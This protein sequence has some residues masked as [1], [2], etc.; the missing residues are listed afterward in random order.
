MTNQG[1]RNEILNRIRETVA[2]RPEQTH[3]TDYQSD[4][5]F[6]PVQESLTTF[7]EELEAIG[8]KCFVAQSE[9]ELLQKLAALFHTRA[10]GSLYCKDQKLTTLISKVN[11]KL[12]NSIEDFE[13]MEAGVTRCECLVARTGSV[14][15]SSAT[16]SGR[17]MHAFPPVHIVIADQGQLV[18]YPDDALR[19][20]Q[21]KYGNDLPSTISFITGPSRTAD[22]EKTLVMGAHGPKEFFIFVQQKP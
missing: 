20:M 2:R 16:G 10:F 3:I 7:I 8:G 11:I 5:I 4:E 21:E 18:S 9:D 1:S 14:V 17:Q 22:I 12:S 15:V 19:L 6:M 13:N